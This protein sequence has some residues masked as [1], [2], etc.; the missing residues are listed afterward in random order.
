M[1]MAVRRSARIVKLLD[2]EV[3][4]PACEREVMVGPYH[5]G[6]LSPVA[7]EEFDDH[8]ASC[9]ACAAELR[10]VQGVSR[11][12]GPLRLPALS[13]AEKEEL[14]RAAIRAVQGPGEE[15]ES[16]SLKLPPSPAIRWVRWVTAAAAAIFLFSV[17]QLFLA[18]RNNPGEPRP[19][20]PGG[21]IPAVHHGTTGPV[22]R[23]PKNSAQPPAGKRPAAQPDRVD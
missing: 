18:Q 21:G 4:M 19:V 23:A 11:W 8:L 16:D 22:E 1:V 3:S 17:V 13:P 2:D 6:E 12:L 7:R 10:R 20:G 5:D 14:A 15:G 9:P